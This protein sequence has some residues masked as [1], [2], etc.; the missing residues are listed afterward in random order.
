MAVPD[1]AL[2]RDKP[3]HTRAQWVDGRLRAAILSNELQ[4]GERLRPNEL[5]AQWG[6]SPTPLREALLRLE[7]DGLVESVPHRGTRVT[8][9]TR[10]A[11]EQLYELRELLEPLALRK[12][13]A[14]PDAVDTD[15]VRAAHAA[16]AASQHS[17]DLVEHE[18]LH[19]E[20]HRALYEACDS[21]WL[22]ALTD[23]LSVHSSRYRLLSLEPRGGWASVVHEHD[24][25]V[26]AFLAGDAGAALAQLDAHIRRTLDC[27]LVLPDL[28][29]E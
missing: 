9:L 28:E 25:L 23:T 18:V 5:A 10:K 17:T 29:P 27:V 14:R 19:R 1:K 11:V 4:P 6:V 22:L 24:V 26:T 20:F 13:M 12:A 2:A 7:A 8:P 15:R 16:L 21:P 3:L